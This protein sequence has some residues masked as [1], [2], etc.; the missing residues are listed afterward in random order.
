M[1]Q[2]QEYLFGIPLSTHRDRGVD[3]AP[4]PYE[5]L[6]AAI[7]ITFFRTTIHQQNDPT[8]WAFAL[9]LGYLTYTNQSYELITSIEIFSYALPYCLFSESL[10]FVGQKKTTKQAKDLPIRFALIV[11]SGCLSFYIC[12]LASSGNLF[13]YLTLI[14][15]SFV[16]DGL[17]TLFPI[18][19]IQAAYNIIDR[20]ILEPGLLRYQVSR[21]FFTTFHIQCGIGYLGID[22]LKQEQERRNQ[23]VRMDLQEERKTTTASSQNNG[24]KAGKKQSLSK[25]EKS[26]NFQRSAA[27]FIFF[28]AV[29]Y[30]LKIIFYGNLNAFAYA[31]FKDDVHRA[32]R[33][34][35]LFDHDNNLVA[36]ANHSAK[37][38]GDY[39][40]YMS[41]V[42]STTY[43]LFNRKL[44]SLPKLM[45]LPMIM[46]KQP[47]MV[48][49]IFPIIFM[50]DWMKGR[51]V[52]Y[53][54]SRIEH[55]EK[56]TQQ[57]MAMR[58]KVESFDIKNAELLQRA[59]EYSLEL[60]QA[61]CFVITVAGS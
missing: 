12:S 29:P 13:R 34:H 55:L 18:T 2:L 54:T 38:P 4:F 24:S 20:F 45:L 47:K 6:I 31:C 59:G 5:L 52:A 22:F 42:V 35:D 25:M 43:D 32:V 17:A 26:R 46:M 51:A 28:V 8:R 33:L 9:I 48:A 30:M 57:L 56:E 40:N 16:N 1:T 49:Q 15:P 10:P 60:V 37:S 14:A 50:T 3:H 23:L 36:L 19:E 61:H 39:G 41:V 7:S 44:F 11:I 27:P 21:L 53:M 58:S